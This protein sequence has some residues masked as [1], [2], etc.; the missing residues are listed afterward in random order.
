MSAG[1]R[2][3]PA[4]HERLLYSAEEAAELLGIGRTFMFALLASGDISS[5]KIGKR[6]K[7]PRD[8]LDDYIQR[9]RSEQHP[10]SRQLSTHAQASLGWSSMQC[11]CSA[12]E[13][14]R[15]FARPF[16]NCVAS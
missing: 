14:R 3:S 8:A 6:R 13:R 12:R 2:R 16:L 7:I 4:V 9:L 11:T 1:A 10:A 5:L 15:P